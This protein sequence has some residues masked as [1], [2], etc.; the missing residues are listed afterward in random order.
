MM[1]LLRAKNNLDRIL[2]VNP[3]A[4]EVKNRNKNIQQKDAI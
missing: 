3:E 1:D 2:N 4:E